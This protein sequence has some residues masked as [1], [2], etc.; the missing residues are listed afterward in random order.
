MAWTTPRTYT[1]G[2]LITKA[3]LD[4]H[5]RDNL[6]YLKA[7]FDGSADQ[8]VTL[9]HGSTDAIAQQLAARKARGSVA[10]PA[11]VVAGDATLDLSSAAYHAGDYRPV[12]LIRANV[13]GVGAT[14]LDG[15]IDLYTFRASDG[16]AALALRLAGGVLQV[17][18]D[19]APGTPA[20]SW[21]SDLNTGLWRPA[22]D[23][24]G[25]ATGGLQRLLVSTSSIQLGTSPVNESNVSPITL[26]GQ[27]LISSNTTLG[28]IPLSVNSTNDGTLISLQRAG[29]EQGSI[30]VTG[31][32]VAYNTFLGAHYT[33]RAPGQG[34]PPVGGVVVATGETIGAGGEPSRFPLVA[35]T[36]QPADP[37]V[38]GVWLG[39]LRAR[40]GAALGDPEAPL[41]QVA[42]VGLGQVRVTDLA[43]DLAPGDLLETSARLYEAQR[44]A[45]RAIRA[46]T[47]GKCLVAV[48][49]AEEPIDPRVGYRWRLVPAVLY[50]G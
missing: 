19:G 29:V 27:A 23:T 14:Y 17:G 10:S 13:G 37:A 7:V 50:A 12:A 26:Y 33:Q 22:A 1:D 49:W 34:A 32:T 3:I 21:L 15:G 2:E 5:L 45:D 31:A 47:L 44:Q 40:A 48:R 8:P 42:G 38:Y 9:S 24:L 46:S 25:L 4:V 28:G 20:L 18:G 30:T 6:A 16:A 35:G 11:D 39:Q 36:I 43:G 41:D